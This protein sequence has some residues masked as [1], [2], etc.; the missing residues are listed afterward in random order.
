M[1][2]KIF[3]ITVLLLTFALI[4]IPVMGA[5]A[6][7][8]EVTVTS[9]VTQTPGPPNV[10][11][12]GIAHVRGTSTGTFDITIQGQVDPLNFAYYGEWIA[13]GKGWPPPNPEYEAVIMGKVT[14]TFIGEGLTGTFEGTTHRKLV[15]LPVSSYMSTHLVLHGTEDFKGQTLKITDD[16]G[17]LIIPK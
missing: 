8:I 4:S 17:Y 12:H 14:L 15:G 2:K 3:V 10:V 9:S 11:D 1:K 7:K 5:P 16:E 13:R 6:T